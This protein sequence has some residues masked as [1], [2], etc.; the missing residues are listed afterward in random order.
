[1]IV[2]LLFGC[3]FEEKTKK[4]Q[5]KTKKKKRKTNKKTNWYFWHRQ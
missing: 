3:L 4:N 2:F 5:K 1:L